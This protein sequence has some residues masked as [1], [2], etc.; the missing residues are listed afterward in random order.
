M[1]FDNSVVGHA[2]K[3]TACKSVVSGDSRFISTNSGPLRI[4]RTRCEAG[5]TYG[6]LLDAGG[7]ASRDAAARADRDDG[8][9]PR[10]DVAA[11]ESAL[12]DRAAGAAAGSAWSSS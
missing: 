7:D 6:S 8:T 3:S 10:R 5:L 11:A 4:A 12:G 9:A 1:L 2:S